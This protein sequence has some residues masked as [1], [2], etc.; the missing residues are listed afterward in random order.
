MAVGKGSM[1]IKS[2]RQYISTK[3]N[4]KNNSK[5]DSENKSCNGK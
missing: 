3:R 1:A 2:S 4:K 5:N